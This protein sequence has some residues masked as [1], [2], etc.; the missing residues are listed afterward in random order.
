MRLVI[1][2]ACIGCSTPPAIVDGGGDAA[3]IVCFSDSGTLPPWQD[4]DAA[5][6]VRARALFEQSCT[7][8]GESSCHFNKEANLDFILEA[9][10]NDPVYGIINIPSTEEPSVMRVVPFHPESSYLY[11]K[12]TGDPRIL[13]GSTPMPAVVAFTSGMVDPEIVALVGP[14]IEAGAP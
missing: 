12:V 11:W 1:V 13:D 7:R 10:V 6:G 5:L 2:C 8:D 14:W 3:C 9:G 4:T